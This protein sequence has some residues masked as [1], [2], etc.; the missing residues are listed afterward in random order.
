[1]Y[2][3]G[4]FTPRNDISEQCGHEPL[5]MSFGGTHESF[6]GGTWEDR[7]GKV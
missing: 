5:C 6:L 2:E 7:T 3:R 4:Q 1:M